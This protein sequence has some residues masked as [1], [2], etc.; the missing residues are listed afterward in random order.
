MITKQALIDVSMQIILHAGD[1][2]EKA[3]RA[4]KYAFSNEFENAEKYMQQAEADLEKAHVAQTDIIQQ[5]LEEDSE[6]FTLLFIHAQD[7]LMSIKSE[8]RTIKLLID[9][10]KKFNGKK[11]E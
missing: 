4:A 2:R 11:E 8:L 1:A 3:D 10:C 9:L 5:S 6:V 7:T